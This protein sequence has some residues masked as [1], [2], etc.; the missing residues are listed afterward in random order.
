M[1]RRSCRAATA[2]KRAGSVTLAATPPT[3]YCSDNDC[4]SSGA[5]L[6]VKRDLVV[7]K[8]SPEW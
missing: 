2:A 4:A 1:G 8:L 5:R 3:L 6:M 7:E